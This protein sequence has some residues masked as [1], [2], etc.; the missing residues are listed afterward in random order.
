MEG[1][2]DLEDLLHQNGGQPHGGLVQ[3]H[4]F[5]AGHQG[6]PHGQ[7]LLFAAGERAGDLAAALLQAGKLLVD[8]LQAG[9]DLTA[10]TGVGAHLQILLHRHLEEDLP[11]FGHLG[12]AP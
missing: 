1:L 6:A 8:G 5:G 9:S 7:H 3:H 11:A 4:Q 12:K 2:D 10:R